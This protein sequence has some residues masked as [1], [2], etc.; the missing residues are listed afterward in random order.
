M[1]SSAE[2][3]TNQDQAEKDILEGVLNSGG[4]ALINMVVRRSRGGFVSVEG[5]LVVVE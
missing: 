2:R 3:L 1:I 5:D 4:N